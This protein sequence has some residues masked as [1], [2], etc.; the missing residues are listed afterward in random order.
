VSLRNPSQ[1]IALAERA[2]ALTGHHDLS[3]L[4]ALAA[5]YASG[6]RYEDAVTIARTAIAQAT[7]LGQPAV[8][9]QFRERLALYEKRQPYRMPR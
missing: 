6:G 1:A 2:A 3:T 4:D 9:S 5:A 8:A 7:M